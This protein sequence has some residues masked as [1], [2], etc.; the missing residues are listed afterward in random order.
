MAWTAEPRRAADRRGLRYPSGPTD[1]EWGLVAPL[2]RPAKHGGGPRKVD[3]REVLNAVFHVLSTGCLWCAPPKGL[4]PKSTVRDHFSRWEWEG[5]IGRIRH[6]LCV[7]ARE[8]AGRGPARRRRSST[9]RRRRARERGL[10]ARPF[11]LRRGPPGAE[12]G[13]C[14]R[15]HRHVEDGVCPPL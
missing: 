4:P 8:G 10:H 3:V 11:R 9:A 12:D 1:A 7:A 6:A 15:P 2:I 5:T 13:G 14:R